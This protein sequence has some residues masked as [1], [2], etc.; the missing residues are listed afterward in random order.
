MTCCG[1]LKADVL[2]QIQ[3]S[4]REY[5]F[6]EHVSALTSIPGL[7]QLAVVYLD[8][9][10]VFGIH[11]LENILKHEEPQNDVKAQKIKKELKDLGISAAAI[12]RLVCPIGW[13]FGDNTPA[14]IS[15]SIAAQLISLKP[16]ENT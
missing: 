3:C 1:H 6:I 13:D 14:E 12:E 11:Y 4:L 9:C 15:I 16:K 5:F 7:W 10:P 8:H 2:P